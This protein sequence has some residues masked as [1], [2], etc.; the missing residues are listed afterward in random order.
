[1]ERHVALIAVA[2][3]VCGI[4]GPLIRFRNQ[5]PVFIMLVDV[6]AKLLEECVR[7]REVFAIRALPLIKIGHGVQAQ[8]VN[9]ALEPEVYDSEHSFLDRWVVEVEIRLVRKKSVPKI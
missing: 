5:Q 1:M 7:L 9:A 4:F 3:I 2:K 8:A 6:A